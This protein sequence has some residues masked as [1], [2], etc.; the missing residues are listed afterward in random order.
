MNS[1]SYLSRQFDALGGARSPRPG[2]ERRRSFL[3]DRHPSRSSEGSKPTRMKTWTTK[4]FMLDPPPSQSRPK[5]SYSSPADLVSLAS[6]TRPMNLDSGTP[7]SAAIDPPAKS[8]AQRWLSRVFLVRVIIF[9]WDTLR[10]AW[11]SILHLTSQRPPTPVTIT[12]LSPPEK[13]TS[14]DDTSDESTP[15]SPSRPRSPHQSHPPPLSTQSSDP[16]LNP[17]RASTPNLATRKSPFHLPK[18]LVLDLDETLIHSTSRPIAWSSS[19]WGFFGRRN[20][21]AGHV[22]EV[23]LAGKSTVY[24]VYKRPFVDFFLRTVRPVPA[25]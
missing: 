7:P 14:D 23:M 19:G 20:Q 8:P 2:T 11:S 15:G 18:T 24:H 13:D 17:S 21:T 12:V 16:G 3:D 9:A 10:N 1:L 25:L 22:V 6:P 4:P 5:R